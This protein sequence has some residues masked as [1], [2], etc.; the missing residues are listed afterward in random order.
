MS[1]ARVSNAMCHPYMTFLKSSSLF[2][3]VLEC[4]IML[5]A[6]TSLNNDMNY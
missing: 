3:N 5:Y 2:H 1:Y 6:C 4:S